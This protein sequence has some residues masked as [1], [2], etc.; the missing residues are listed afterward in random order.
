MMIAGAGGVTSVAWPGAGALL[1]PGT[2]RWSTLLDPGSKKA[3]QTGV[4]GY[5]YLQDRN[6]TC[7]TVAAKPQCD[8]ESHDCVG[9]L[10]EN[11][12]STISPGRQGTW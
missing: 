10:R 8:S 11:L 3:G 1:S 6:V 7:Q 4:E 2:L 12:F 5:A 9:I